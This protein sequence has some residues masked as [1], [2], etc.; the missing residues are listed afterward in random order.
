MALK[1]EGMNEPEVARTINIIASR[2]EG[3]FYDPI[4]KGEPKFDTSPNKLLIEAARNRKPGKALDVGMGQGRN[5]IY[6]ARNGWQVTGFDVS[7]EGLGA[8]QKL[9]GEAGVKIR[10]ELASDE[11]FDFGTEAWDLIA[12]LYPIEKRSVFRVRQAL[13]KGGIV[14]IECG[15]KE[16]GNKPFEYETNE[17]LKIFDG[18]RILKYEDTLA[19]HDWTR[20]EMRI[21]R[22]IAEK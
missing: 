4:F 8:A 7:R 16:A 13:K 19:V 17:L 21:V 6:L 18:F 1:A 10:T 20:K 3:E 12:I 11:E 22:L 9:A 14:V 2:D 5:A 15:H